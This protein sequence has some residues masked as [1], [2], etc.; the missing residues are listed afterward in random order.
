VFQWLVTT[1]A[2]VL[3]TYAGAYFVLGE[4]T[5]GL[6]G[7]GSYGR[8][9]RTRVIARAFGPMGWVESRARGAMIILDGEGVGDVY[10]R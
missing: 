10:Y 8:E 1:T 3:V 6:L 4:Y 5:P 7:P 9:F 2:L